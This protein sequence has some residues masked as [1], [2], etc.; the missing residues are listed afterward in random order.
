MTTKNTNSTTATFENMPEI[1][2]GTVLVTDRGWSMVLP[3]FY[4]VVARTESS[5]WTKEIRSIS[6]AS[7]EYGTS[8]TKVADLTDDSWKVDRRTCKRS[9]QGSPL[10]KR[11]R[12]LRQRLG[13]QAQDVRLHG[14]KHLN[15][16]ENAEPAGRRK[17]SRLRFG[18]IAPLLV[19]ESGA[20]V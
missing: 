14:L 2:V 18:F 4:R 15:R 3:T 1:E 5:I 9:H 17:P 7:D 11:R 10:R 20:I 6:A 19:L 8:G 13:R 12:T 16:Q